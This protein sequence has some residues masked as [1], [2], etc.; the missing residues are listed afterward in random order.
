[1]EFLNFLTSRKLTAVTLF[2]ALILLT[3]LISAN[4]FGYNTLDNCKPET[5]NI[6]NIYENNT[7]INQTLELN[8]TQF[9]SGE[10]ATIKESWL[11]SFIEAVTKWA[12]YY[13]KTESD[14]KFVPFD[15]ADQ[16]VDLGEN[17]L[18]VGG[19]VGIGKNNSSEK[20]EVDGNI[21]LSSDKQ[22]IIQGAGEEYTQQFD[23]TNQR[24]D[25][26]TGN[27][28]FN[29]P[30]V[31]T[32]SDDGTFFRRQADQSQYLAI[33]TDASSNR[34]ISTNKRLEFETND[35]SFPIRFSSPGN[36]MLNIR[37]GMNTG[38]EAIL[39]LGG[40][41]TATRSAEIKSIIQGTNSRDVDLAFSLDNS[42]N[43]IE[44]M[45]L[46]YEGRLGIGKDNPSE[47]LDV[48]GNVKA[49][50]SL[51]LGNNT[52]GGL[53]NGDINA[54][55]IYYNVLQAKSPI[56]L[57][58]EN[59]CMV[60]LPQ[61][62]EG[63]YLQKDNDWNV[64]QIT[65]KS[66]KTIDSKEFVYENGFIVEAEK[67]ETLNEVLN[68]TKTLRDELALDRQ[69]KAIIES[70]LSQNYTWKDN[71]CY[72]IYNQAVTYEQA[73]EDKTIYKTESQEYS[74]IELNPETL[75]AEET[76]CSRQIET[77]EI[78]RT[79]RVFKEGCNWNREIG[80]YCRM[81]VKI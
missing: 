15:G 11:T 51:A 47:K 39:R 6:T 52:M 41:G 73:T 42:G 63:F 40:F 19:N 1:M 24:F 56:I 71:A 75:R 10:P 55:T 9:E 2:F 60:E 77:T 8:S 65:D 76:I 28:V 13:T 80:Y 12:N 67:I 45:R 59:W 61:A 72:N 70:C 66:G 69:Q 21:K 26:T 4:C 58:S 25:L 22:T 50:G 78:E 17:D 31:I 20:L 38:D 36:T 43:L 14:N 33:F 34:F 5:G 57:C 54:S 44:R 3:P 46:T 32:N 16:D 27:F 79:Q 37:G 29:Q 81:E 62:K 23:G 18:Y 49:N 74:C 30:I 7:Y 35:A 68:K 64:L 53:S 48:D